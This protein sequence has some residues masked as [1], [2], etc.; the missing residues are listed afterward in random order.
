MIATEQLYMRGAVSPVGR[1]LVSIGA[2]DESASATYHA[3]LKFDDLN[4]VVLRGADDCVRVR[5][6]VGLWEPNVKRAPHERCLAALQ[7]SR[8]RRLVLGS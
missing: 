8:V 4:P 1:A 6:V 2:Y 5:H 3:A 7:L